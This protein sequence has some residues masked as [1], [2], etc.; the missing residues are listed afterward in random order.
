MPAEEKREKSVA[1]LLYEASDGGGAVANGSSRA[2]LD[3]LLPQVYDELHRIAALYLRRERAGHTLQPTALVNE[4][5]LKLI[6]QRNVD[7]RNRAQFFGVAANLMRRILLKH[8]ER[9][10]AEKRGGGAV[11]GEAVKIAL[12]DSKADAAATTA[13]MTIYCDEQNLDFL[14]L[15][16]ALEKLAA[17]DAQKARVVELKFFGGLKAEEISEVI[18]KSVKTVE[19]DWTFARAWLNREL[20]R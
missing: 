16:E 17:L 20:N 15:D 19:R 8:A 11:N 4:A 3:A 18:G 7:W 13:A 5:Y 2:A 1:Q 9:K 10:R 6:D 14:A 12:D